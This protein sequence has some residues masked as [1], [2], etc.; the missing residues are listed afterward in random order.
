MRDKQRD[1][2]LATLGIQ[3]LHFNGREVIKNTD[4]A[5]EVILRS[6]EESLA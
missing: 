1:K 3:A 4:S 2:Y 6:V 5:V